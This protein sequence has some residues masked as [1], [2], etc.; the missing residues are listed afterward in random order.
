MALL[1]SQQTFPKQSHHF[2]FP[3]AV[4]ESSSCSVTS[5]ALGFVSF[6]ILAILWVCSG[7]LLWF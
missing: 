1:R 3:P 5:S 2:I 4:W 6:F 7:I